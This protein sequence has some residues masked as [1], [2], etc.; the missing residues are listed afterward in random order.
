[1]APNSSKDDSEDGALPPAIIAQAEA[2][3]KGNFEGGRPGIRRSTSHQV[4]S[5]RETLQTGAPLSK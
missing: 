4:S 5:E 1:M 2:A 3:I